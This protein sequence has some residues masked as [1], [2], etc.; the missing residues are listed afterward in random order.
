MFNI[1]TLDQVR[2]IEVEATTYCNAGCPHCSRHISNTSKIDPDMQMNQ[3]TPELI[4]KLKDDF[5]EQT[6]KM[7]I[8]YVG[9]LGDA[10][11]HKNIDDILEFSSD[12]FKYVEM[13]T[14]GGARTKEFWKRL[15]SISN[16]NKNLMMY[17]SID[18]LEDTNEIYR[19]KVNWNKLI[20]NIEAYMSTGGI[21]TWKWLTFQHNEHQL[22]EAKVLAKKLGFV[23][24]EPMLATRYDKKTYEASPKTLSKKMQVVS[25]YD[26]L[27][28]S[29]IQ[30]ASNVSEKIEKRLKKINFDT[31]VPKIDCKYIKQKRMYLNAQGRIWPCCWTAEWDKYPSLDGMDPLMKSHYKNGFNDYYTR[32][33]S[34]IFKDPAWLE[35]TDNWKLKAESGQR[36]PMRLCHS[37]CTNSKWEAMCNLREQSEV[38]EFKQTNH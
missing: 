26:Q 21:A 7:Q 30:L 38:V 9:N 33:M 2:K 13:E 18:G 35:M 12:N 1:L 28:T 29:E 17:F 37:K 34:E 16:K 31:D 14:N 11:M 5:G 19:K 22:E 23:Q 4:Y 36:Q 15:G 27:K 32:S 10:L 20:Q 25:N 8:W 24:F 6:K 3:I